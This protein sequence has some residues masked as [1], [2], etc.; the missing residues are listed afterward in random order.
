MHLA[1]IHPQPLRSL[2]HYTYCSGIK[3]EGGKKRRGRNK[4]CERESGTGGPT[5]SVPGCIHV[6]SQNNAGGADECHEECGIVKNVSSILNRG[7][8]GVLPFP[9]QNSIIFCEND[10]IWCMFQCLQIILHTRRGI[11]KG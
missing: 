4:R 9:E 11:F 3:G 1:D 8:G 2:K 10:A 5:F 7:L 6:G